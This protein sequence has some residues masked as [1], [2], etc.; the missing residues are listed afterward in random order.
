MKVIGIGQRDAAVAAEV[1]ATIA[2]VVEV[3]RPWGVDARRVE[4][5]MRDALAAG[6]VI[7]PTGERLDRS[8]EDDDATRL[9]AARRVFRA[10]KAALED[11]QRG[12]RRVPNPIRLTGR[13]VRERF[14]A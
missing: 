3:M 1:K 13:V 10:A 11:A 6:W 9:A 12:P 14:E 5:L 4:V 2:Q 7:A 8:T